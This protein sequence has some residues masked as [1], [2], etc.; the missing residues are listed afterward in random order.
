M[1]VQI[2]IEL[3][4]LLKAGWTLKS[5]SESFPEWDDDNQCENEVEYQFLVI[6]KDGQEF[7]SYCLWCFHADCNEWGS[8]KE[9]FRQAG[10]LDIPHTLS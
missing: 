5:E 10:L 1:G 4:E 2:T 6:L 8:N 9:R 7:H 3:A